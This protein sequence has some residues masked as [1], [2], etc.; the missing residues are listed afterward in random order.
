MIGEIV[1]NNKNS[2]G[3]SRSFGATIAYTSQTDERHKG[4]SPE[5]RATLVY[6][7]HLHLAPE[8]AADEMMAVAAMNRI[9][10]RCLHVVISMS[11]GE[12]PTSEQYSEICAHALKSM[13]YED[14]QVIAYLQN[15]N[16]KNHLHLTIN[17]LHP[18]TYR[19]A[20]D[21]RSKQRLELAMREL[22]IKQGW[23]R[24]EGKHWCIYKDK[25]IWTSKYEKIIGRKIEYGKEISDKAIKFEKNTGNVSFERHWKTSQEARQLRTELKAV[26]SKSN[27]TWNEVHKCFDKHNLKLEAYSDEKR[28][29]NGFVIVDKSDPKARITASNFDVHKD[30]FK[31]GHLVKAIGT[32]YEAPALLHRGNKAAGYTATLEK[33]KGNNPIFTMY[34]ANKARYKA[35]MKDLNQKYGDRGAVISAI[36]RRTNLKVQQIERAAVPKFREHVSKRR[37]TKVTK[38]VD[39][40]PKDQ[41]KSWN[42]GIA[43]KEVHEG[44][45]IYSVAGHSIYI[46]RINV[47]KEIEAVKATAAKEKQEVRKD[48]VR[49]K[50]EL[51]TR[52]DS[53]RGDYKTYLA[54]EADKGN[55]E[56]LPELARVNSSHP[57]IKN[58]EIVVD[59]YRGEITSPSRDIRNIECEVQR[60][61][62]GEDHIIYRWQD[63]KKEIFVDK[64]PTIKCVEHTKEAITAMVQ[65]AAEKFDGQIHV[66]AKSSEAFKSAVIDVAIRNGF[67]IVNPELKLQVH[68]ARQNKNTVDHNKASQSPEQDREKTPERDKSSPDI[69]R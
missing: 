32:P 56:V 68:L 37:G 60:K 51:E 16:G 48:Y 12:E 66:G 49:E 41:D 5:E 35:A 40:G 67:T 26:L 14:H 27:P 22:E 63:T 58:N 44:A 2:G 19:V 31:S 4:M 62:I 6:S 24:V 52:Y 59:N 57:A 23:R 11:P 39:F 53:C 20:K 54:K 25:P 43:G 8:Y 33:T 38:Y 18:E 17:R 30:I 10:E 21:G 46:S 42:I 34:S 28:G 36:D 69:E 55:V 7:Q 45:T 15:D 50:A 29:R 3:S 1:D 13:G 61:M 9:N 47:K 65:L 64:G